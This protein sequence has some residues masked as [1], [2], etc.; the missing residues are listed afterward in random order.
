M[1]SGI[2]ITHEE[3][4]NRASWGIN[5]A[6]D[7]IDDDCDGHGTHVAGIIAGKKYGVANEAKVVAIKVYDCVGDGSSAKAIQ[8]IEWIMQNH[9]MSK[10]ATVNMSFVVKPVNTALNDAANNLHNSG[11]PTVVAAGNENVNACKRSPASATDVITVGATTKADARWEHSNWG[12]CVNIMA[13]GAKIRSAAHYSDTSTKKRS[14]TSMATPHVCGAVAQLLEM[15]VR[16]ADVRSELITKMATEDVLTNLKKGTPN[17]LLNVHK[18]SQS[19]ALFDFK[20]KRRDCGW[21][22]ARKGRIC[23]R[24]DIQRYCPSTCGACDKWGCADAGD[25]SIPFYTSTKATFAWTCQKVQSLTEERRKKLCKNHKFYTTCRITCDE[26]CDRKSL[27]LNFDDVDD[28]SGHYYHPLIQ[29]TCYRYLDGKKYYPNEGFG[30]GVISKPMIAYNCASGAPMT[31][32]CP[33]GSFDLLSMYMTA[34]W[35][36]MPALLE[37][38]RDGT[39]NATFSLTLS[40]DLQPK[41]FE[42]EFSS[43]TNLDSL[44]IS[45]GTGTRGDQIVL[46]DVEIQINSNCTV[47]NPN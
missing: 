4:E 3:F 18:C 20:G 35:R 36:E 7:G 44:V 46:D 10:P 25:E 19:T 14:G 40:P 5:L 45:T 6:G 2:R 12:K 11:I 30:F 17:K 38:Y 34:G 43:F 26:Q 16:P 23:K 37:G 22:N 15:G 29:L 1:D 47:T 27:L 28:D 32:S 39:V 24:K 33:G 21:V 8:G 9:D 41:Y 13:P 42:S 31:M